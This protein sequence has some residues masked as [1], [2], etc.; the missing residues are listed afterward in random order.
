MGRNPKNNDGNKN[1]PFPLRL[2]DPHNKQG[3]RHL[4]ED[5]HDCP[6]IER[7]RILKERAEK[8]AKTGPARSTRSQTDDR[9]A[10]RLATNHIDMHHSPL[11]PVIVSDGIASMNDTRR[12]DDSSDNSIAS[13]LAAQQA[14]LKGI[15]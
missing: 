6:E 10:G 14:V 3:I 5:W 9:T 15:G 12:N 11:C 4:L 7:D 13:S 8:K 1:K 2:W